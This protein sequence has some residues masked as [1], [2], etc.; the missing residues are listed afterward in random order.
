MGREARSTVGNESLF[1][2]ILGSGHSNEM[3]HFQFDA[4]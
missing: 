4:I 3:A 1:G 2:R